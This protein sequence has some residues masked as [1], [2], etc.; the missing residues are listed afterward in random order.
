MRLLPAFSFGSLT[1][2]SLVLLYSADLMAASRVEGAAAR[3]GVAFST[4]STPAQLAAKLDQET[5]QLVIVDL[6]SPGLDVSALVDT[7]RKGRPAPPPIIAFGPH[8][9]EPL[10]AA[11]REAGCDEVVSRGQFFAKLD[12]FV[13]RAAG[14]QK[15]N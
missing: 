13:R 12:E 5:V 8:V 7:V 11:A 9:H 2:L 6:S 10:L 14:G 3:A 4:V 1:A 15:A